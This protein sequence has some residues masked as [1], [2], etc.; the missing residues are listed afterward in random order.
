MQQN[1]DF[2]IEDVDQVE[3]DEFFNSIQPESENENNVPI[4]DSK[5]SA[6]KWLLAYLKMESEIEYL[7]DV[8]KPYQKERYLKP[9]EDRIERLVKSQDFIKEG[10]LK[11]LE[12]AELDSVPFP[13]FA[14]VS[15][16]E[17]KDKII[18]PE[19]EEELAENL[20]K[21]GNK[22][23]VKIKH[24]LDKKA[25]NQYIA[26]NDGELPFSGLSIEKVA[27]SVRVTRSKAY[28]ASED[29]KK[30]KA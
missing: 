29:K 19:N 14:T 26:N 2:K 23:F 5:L 6:R 21:S 24:S 27:D 9:T 17:G 8:Y 28:K 3:F 22:D 16:A 12:N 11:F 1:S 4:P 18:Y 13:D 15:K 25:I 10:L 20:F 7:S 30:A